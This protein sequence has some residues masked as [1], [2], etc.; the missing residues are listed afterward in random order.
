MGSRGAGGAANDSHLWRKRQELVVLVVGD[1]K[2][3]MY[4]QR[5]ERTAPAVHPFCKKTADGEDLKCKCFLSQWSNKNIVVRPEN[6]NVF[7]SFVLKDRKSK[8][9]SPSLGSTKYAGVSTAKSIQST[10]QAHM[11]ENPIP[12]LAAL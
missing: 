10:I 6:S 5:G 7:F 3:L 12:S 4:P 9:S 1:L 11:Q 8:S 2:K